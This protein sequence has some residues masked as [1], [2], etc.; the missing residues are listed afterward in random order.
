MNYKNEPVF[1]QT[2][3]AIV[4]EGERDVYIGKARS[5]QLKEAYKRHRYGR[6]SLT[7]ETVANALA[8]GTSFRIF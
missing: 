7:K 5:D 1:K 3:Y 6:Y 2:V 8:I 4:I